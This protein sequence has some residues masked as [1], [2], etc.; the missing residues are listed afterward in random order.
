MRRYKIND[1][2]LYD[3]VYSRLRVQSWILNGGVRNQNFATA[4]RMESEQAIM[5]TKLS[6]IGSKEGK[7]YDA[8]NQEWI[9]ARVPYWKAVL[10][11]VDADFK[12][13]SQERVNQGYA[14]PSEMP[15]NLAEK[16]AE[17]EA[18]LDIIEDELALCNRLL[19]EYSEK[20]SVIR[21]ENMLKRGLQQ[22]GKL[23]GGFLVEM[24]YQRVGINADGI[25]I[26]DDSNSP[27]DGMGVT[28]YRA[29][30]NKWMAEFQDKCSKA[31]NERA[32]EIRRK[33]KSNIALPS[34]MDTIPREQLPK[35]PNGVVNYK[36]DKVKI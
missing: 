26:I 30:A 18:A 21:D 17:A 28:D 13:Y 8:E 25:L 12:I 15:T 16:Q 27:Y 33:G 29:L 19:K 4:G 35:W 22:S 24:D 7:Y 11:K 6:L 20:V 36:K 32:E 23:R 5:I 14:R 2:S 31:A 1:N 3:K 9:I 10:E 34:R